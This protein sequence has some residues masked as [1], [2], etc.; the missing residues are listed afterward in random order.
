VRAVLQNR[1][2][3]FII[4]IKKITNSGNKTAIE[5]TV[6]GSKFSSIVVPYTE[7]E[8]SIRLEGRYVNRAS[9]NTEYIVMNAWHWTM[10]DWIAGG[11]NRKRP[12]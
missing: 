12:V 2:K 4:E 10:L 8:L 5:E 6:D 11:D 3:K 1:A 7:Q 9:G